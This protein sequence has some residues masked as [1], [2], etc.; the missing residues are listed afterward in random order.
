MHVSPICNIDRTFTHIFFLKAKISNTKSVN[1][2]YQNPVILAKVYKRMINS[3][4]VKS[5][6][7]LAQKLGISK[8][9]VCRVLSLLKL[10]NE[11]LNAVEKIGNPMPTRV[12]TERMLRACL[13]SPEIYKSVMF[14]LSDCKE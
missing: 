8:V 9:H 1:H 14:R 12:V 5:Q 13:K 11:L 4:E 7:D 3:G 2:F 6:T 10:D